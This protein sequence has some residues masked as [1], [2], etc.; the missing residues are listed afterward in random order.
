MD[1]VGKGEKNSYLILHLVDCSLLVLRINWNPNLDQC[2]IAE[3]YKELQEVG[4]TEIPEL[5]LI[6]T[7]QF[8]IGVP[9]PPPR[10]TIIEEPPIT[11]FRPPRGGFV[12]IFPFEEERRRRSIFY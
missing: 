12:P 6:T 4:V 1:L 11:T 2:L 9:I 8:D 5:G 10:T 7:P 3:F